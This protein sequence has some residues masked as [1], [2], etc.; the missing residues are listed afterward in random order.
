MVFCFSDS[1]LLIHQMTG[2]WRLR[3][4]KLRPLF[5]KAKDLEKTFDEVV[6][7]HVMRSD[8]GIQRADRILNNAF[9]GRDI[10][11]LMNSIPQNLY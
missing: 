4:N 1:Q 10:S 7:Q 6:Y 3:N 5:L 9:E 11:N 8:P 2:S